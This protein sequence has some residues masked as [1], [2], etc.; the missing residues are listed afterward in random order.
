MMPSLFGVSTY[1]MTAIM[2]VITM[3]KIASFVE[4]LLLL[5]DIDLIS[6]P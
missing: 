6:S 3:P 2:T 1:V 5:R 4:I